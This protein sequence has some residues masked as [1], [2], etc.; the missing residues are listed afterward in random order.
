MASPSVSSTS[1]TESRTNG[2][3]SKATSALRPGG[4]LFESDA[5]SFF[6]RSPTSSALAVGSWSTPI[7]TAGR[8]LCRVIVE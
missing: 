3:V 6:A 2:V 8:P 7:P 5:S 4:K 1:R